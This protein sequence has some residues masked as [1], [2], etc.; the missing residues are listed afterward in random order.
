MRIPVI[1]NRSAR[2]GN[3]HGELEALEAAFRDAGC[4]AEIIA[5]RDGEDLCEVARR[6]ASED[7]PAV[8]AA[9]GDGTVNA[10]A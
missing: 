1:A 10:V 6:V 7:P 9:G 4:E 2:Q 3:A 5:M 8:V